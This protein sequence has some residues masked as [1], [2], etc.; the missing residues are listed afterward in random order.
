MKPDALNE[1]VKTWL[2]TEMQQLQS[3]A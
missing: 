2:E 1:Q 3:Y